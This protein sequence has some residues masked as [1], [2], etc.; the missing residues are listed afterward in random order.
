MTFIDLKKNYFIQNK[1]KLNN[2]IF[3]SNDDESTY[4]S[5][6]LLDCKNV[7][8]I[9]DYKQLKSGSSTR[10]FFQTISAGDFEYSKFQ[11][12]KNRSGINSQNEIKAF[13]YRNV[14]KIENKS[15]RFIYDDDFI[16]KKNVIKNNLYGS[17][18][19]FKED[20]PYQELNFGFCNYNT[21][22]FSKT[23]NNNKHYNLVSYANLYHDDTDTN[24]YNFYE[25]NKHFSISAK[26]IYRSN[27]EVEKDKPECIVNV[28]GICN[29]YALGA[30]DKKIRLGLTTN[31]ATTKTLSESIQ[32]LISTN[33][34]DED[35]FYLQRINEG[36]IEYDKWYT[37]TFVYAGKIYA[38]LDDDL[39]FTTTYC[40][41]VFND[42]IKSKNNMFN[43]GNSLTLTDKNYDLEDYFNLIFNNNTITS[44][45]NVK[46][47]RI[48]N[49][50]VIINNRQDISIQENNLDECF[51]GELSDIRCYASALNIEKIR[52]IHNNYVS[53]LSGEI[54]EGLCFY[55]PVFFVPSESS[56]KSVI[57]AS[58]DLEFKK[59]TCYYNEVFANSCLGLESN[60]SNYLID[61]VKFAKPNIIVNKNADQINYFDETLINSIKSSPVHYDIFKGKSFSRL[62][63]DAES[64][65][66]SYISELSIINSLI[67]PNDNGIPNVYFNI[68]EEFIENYKENKFDTNIFVK[69]NNIKDYYN[70]KCDNILNEEYFIQNSIDYKNNNKYK[71]VSEIRGVDLKAANETLILEVLDSSP[72]YYT[73][74]GYSLDDISN[75]L[76]YQ[77]LGNSYDECSDEIGDRGYTSF[78]K[79]NFENYGSNPITREIF[80]N[81][82]TEQIYVVKLINDP[83]GP[84]TFKKLPLPYSDFNKDNDNLFINIFDIT[85][86]MYNKKLVRGKISLSDKLSFSNKNI[87]L[88][89]NKYGYIYRS[90]CKTKQADW[91]YVGH[92]FYNEGI[93]CINNPSLYF[94][95]YKDLNVN[96]EAESYIYTSEV[97]VPLDS[98]MINLSQN[99]TYD[100]TLRID[101]AAFNVE[102]KFVYITDINFHD[103]NYNIVAKSKIANPV[104][105]KNTDRF[106]FKL[107]MDY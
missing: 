30:N 81:D 65:L 25:K 28:P 44:P 52:L 12:S 64:A 102:D 89:D 97:N 67:L 76:F 61:F 41:V 78:I 20:E 75:I 5:D 107:K 93:I 68:I 103:E 57:N 70:I 3:Y 26:I 8:D 4:L 38:Y 74:T 45:N 83:S 22:N 94:F 96:F 34:A 6:N 24:T 37:I 87:T 56:S 48:P 36:S 1:I 88:K 21:L 59:S 84:I 32:N 42:S 77:N 18:Y 101:Q 47:I 73:F 69:S 39:L 23:D 31:D 106:I 86:K 17:Y 90:D 2:K 85:N 99:K 66:E 60:I 98:G 10:S 19:V 16:Y 62:L 15:A 95:G 71:I 14:F 7:I 49:S 51:K 55:I 13:N 105:K 80:D 40:S 58:G 82:T 54:K 27:S 92:V 29:I 104:A 100:E 35:N 46:D 53:S 43:I 91:N 72:I 50:L 63:Y 11:I 33:L 9:I 79:N